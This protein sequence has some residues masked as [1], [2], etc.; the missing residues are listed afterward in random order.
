[1]KA[2]W[3][4]Q[5]VFTAVFIA[6]L[7]FC[8]CKN[9][10]R[11][12][13]APPLIR[14]ADLM[15]DSKT[16]IDSHFLLEKADLQPLQQ[17]GWDVGEKLITAKEKRVAFILPERLWR[18]RDF[19][20]R[21]EAR[22]QE[23]RELLVQ[24]QGKE[25]ARYNL[26][27]DWKEYF[28]QYTSRDLKKQ[29]VKQ[30]QFLFGGQPAASYAEFQSFQLPLYS[31]GRT[32][33]AGEVRTALSVNSKSKV[34]FHL[35]LPS[36]SPMLFFGVGVPVEKGARSEAV[37]SVLI[38]SKKGS[39]E[40]I[41][42]TV[43]FPEP[44]PVWKD[45]KIDLRKYAGEDV[46]LEFQVQSTL[47]RRH[48]VAWSS[49]E[50]YDLET[51]ETKPNIIF[52]SI[53]TMRADRLSDRTSPNLMKLARQSQVFT[54]AYCT[55]P[56]TLPSHTSIMTGLY[57]ANHQVSRPVESVVRVKQIPNKL[58]TV[59]EIA[60][61]TNYFTTGITDGGFVSSF[62][63]FDRGFQQY[64]ENV[65][66]ARKDVA[67]ISN[68][69]KW[70][71]K[72][73]QRPFFLF[74]HTYEVHEPFNPPPDVFR[75]LFPNPAMNTP[76]IITMDLLH[77]VVSGAVVPTEEQKEFIRQCYDAE[78]YFFDQ[79]FGLLLNELKRLNLDQNTVILVFSDHGELF[80]EKGN[81]LGHGKTLTMNEIRVP[82]I[83]HVPGKNASQRN[84][85]VSLVDIYPTLVEIMGAKVDTQLDG[86]SLL[87]PSD[88]KKRL[89]RSIYYE[90]TYGKEAMWGA[91]TREFKMVLD[92]QK[93]TEYFYDLRKDPNQETN[94]S[95]TATRSLQSMKQLLAAYVQ[96]STSLT[97][98]AKSK[99]D[100]QETEELREQLKALGYLN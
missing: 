46:V 21:F 41:R 55:F 2:C 3:F 90:V 70:L 39:G 54:N 44:Y 17:H 78:V 62:F 11:G 43:Q 53:D 86:I 42:N 49:P 74:L 91:Q 71:N 12:P 48:Y 8:S 96:K 69:M 63:G 45:E 76:P 47:P 31:W 14:L 82:L 10:P 29:T 36:K 57:V 83:L 34:R 5:K 23:P 72:N 27:S 28:I 94:I 99:Q 22:S 4:S 30:I 18:S 52:V 73:S 87:E 95:H 50:I 88:S 37:F 68:A 19:R 84:D 26:T 25:I 20:M 60:L 98:W 64:S 51:K 92:K 89:N 15:Q 7:L 38:E 93:G 100:K 1:M 75:K 79:N 35:R 65:H 40:L 9:E 13:E 32:R 33:I 24:V 85:L 67:T 58:P 56:S 16:E 66:M 80:L 97:E 6:L 61:R 81:P 77:Q 59:A